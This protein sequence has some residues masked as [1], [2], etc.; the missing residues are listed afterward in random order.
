MADPGDAG[1]QGEQFV[2]GEVAAHLA[3]PMAAR[4]FT[5]AITARPWKRRL[6]Q[7][8]GFGLAHE[9]F[10]ISADKIFG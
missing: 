8:F 5:H 10:G 2:D 1:G 6:V 4:R 3:R 7:D 9:M